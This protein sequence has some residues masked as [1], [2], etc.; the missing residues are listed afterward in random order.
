MKINILRCTVSKISKIIW[1][2]YKRN[3][4]EGAEV[5][6]LCFSHWET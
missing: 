2:F 6:W 3:H 4:T 5:L 1:G